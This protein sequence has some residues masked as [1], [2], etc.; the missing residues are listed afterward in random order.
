MPE[1]TYLAGHDA[2]PGY[3]AVPEGPGPWPG[4]VVIHD[5]RGMTADVRALADRFADAGYLALAPDLFSGVNRIVCMVRAV[6]S[7][8]SGEGPAIDTI[9]AARDY[10]MADERCSGKIGVAGFCFGG[11]LALVVAPSGHFD[12]AACNYGLVP[13]DS[14]VLEKSCPVVASFGGRDRIVKAGSAA[15]LD[16]AL[17]SHDVPHDI[18]E[19]PGVGHAFM[20]SSAL[21]DRIR[22]LLHMSYSGPE[23]EDSWRRLFAFFDEYLC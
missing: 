21:P 13:K 15:A 22:R 2:R 20:N 4:V 1:I 8:F 3:L 19:Y 18:K 7:H 23:A 16:D 10:L 11:G 14:D 6:E 5:I 17:T 12:A 9:G